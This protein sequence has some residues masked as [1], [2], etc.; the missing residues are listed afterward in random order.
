[1]GAVLQMTRAKL[2]AKR[3]DLPAS[4]GFVSE[5]RDEL[6]AEIRAEVRGSASQLRLEMTELRTELRAEMNELRAEVSALRADLARERDERRAGDESLHAML[7]EVLA[8][9]HRT[10]ALVEAQASENRIM[11]EALTGF[12]QR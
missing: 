2:P 9:V 12:V 10:Q 1:M 4:M 8:A 3:R 6:R 5:V 7:Q 11:F